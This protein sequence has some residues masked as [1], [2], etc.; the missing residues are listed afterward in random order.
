MKRVFYNLRIRRKFIV[1][2]L[3]FLKKFILILEKKNNNKERL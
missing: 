2:F 1:I 3:N